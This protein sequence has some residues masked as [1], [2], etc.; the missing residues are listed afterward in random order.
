MYVCVC[1]YMC[2]YV[3]IRVH[4]CVSMC[5][6]TVCMYIF[7]THISI[8]THTYTYIITHAHTLTDAEA[9]QKLDSVQSG[10]AY[11]NVVPPSIFVTVPILAGVF[12]Y[13]CVES[14]GVCVYASLTPHRT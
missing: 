7:I 4:M 14:D 5:M 3:C 12:V 6:R 13:V 8:R 9:K 11:G 2:V 1:A 10:T